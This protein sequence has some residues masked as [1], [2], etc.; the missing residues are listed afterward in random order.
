M[1]Y[2]RD[3]NTEHHIEAPWRTSYVS[4][5]VEIAGKV[6]L[7]A[8]DV[9]AATG[10][11]GV[12]WGYPPRLPPPLPQPEAGGPGHSGPPDPGRLSFQISSGAPIKKQISLDATCPRVIWI[13][14]EALGGGDLPVWPNGS[15]PAV[16]P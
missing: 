11:T 3:A 13:H 7:S 10:T 9:A 16:Q 5:V 4:L 1:S 6:C 14:K 8:N 12:P 15:Q 2:R